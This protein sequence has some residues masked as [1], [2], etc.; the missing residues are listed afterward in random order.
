MKMV[1][2]EGRIQI[3]RQNMWV[4]SMKLKRKKPTWYDS[5]SATFN[6]IWLIIRTGQVISSKIL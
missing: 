3:T 4:D 5:I 6:A 1:D 2:Y